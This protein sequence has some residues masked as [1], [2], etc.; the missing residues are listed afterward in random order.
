[1]FQP[2]TGPRPHQTDKKTVDNRNSSPVARTMEQ[3]GASTAR[4]AL[5]GTRTQTGAFV[6]GGRGAAARRYWAAQHN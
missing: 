6:R 1:M 2:R 5:S 4:F 3:A